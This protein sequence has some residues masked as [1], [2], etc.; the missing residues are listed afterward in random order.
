MHSVWRSA[1]FDRSH[2]DWNRSERDLGKG[3]PTLVSFKSILGP[4]EP[5]VTESIQQK[6]KF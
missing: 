6:D 3:K 4:H 2:R 1:S 5:R